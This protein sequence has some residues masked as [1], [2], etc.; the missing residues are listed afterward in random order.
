MI[1]TEISKLLDEFK[2]LPKDVRQPTFLEICRFPRWRFEEICSRILCFYIDPKNEHGLSNLFLTSLLEVLGDENIRI[3]EQ[4]IAVFNEVYGDGVKLDI[5][6]RG[7]GFVIGIENK[8][9]ARLDNPLDKYRKII[10][11]GKEAKIFP[12]VLSLK[13]L[14]KVD[15]LEEVEKNKFM[16]ITYPDLFRVIKQN[17]GFYLEH[18]NEKYLTHL[19]EF[20]TTLENMN[21]ENLM[22]K[23]LDDFFFDK[24]E[25][26]K[27]LIKLHEDY[28]ARI[29]DAQKSKILEF[30]DEIRKSTGDANWWNYG[31][32][33]LGFNKFNSAMPEI[34]VEGRFEETKG[35]PLGNFKIY[36]KVWKLENW[37]PYANK[38]KAQFPESTA[39]VEGKLKTLFVFSIEGHDEEVIIDKMEYCYNFLKGITEG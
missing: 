16:Q 23:E 8:I 27:N 15:E 9:T 14:Y 11:E 29:I 26:I 6:I 31:G 21:G 24:E 3:D 2:E 39:T 33:Y 35:N 20:M 13:K 28:R 17:I 4:D 1:L 7:T 37:T 5:L 10:E 38:L 25:E 12:V 30:T 19:L 36:I 32:L 18:A 34:G 22:N